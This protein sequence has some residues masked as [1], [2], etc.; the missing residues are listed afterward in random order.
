MVLRDSGL[1]AENVP[2]EALRIKS[3]FENFNKMD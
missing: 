1:K 3:S 2:A